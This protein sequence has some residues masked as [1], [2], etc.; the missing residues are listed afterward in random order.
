LYITGEFPVITTEGKTF[1]GQ[2]TTK[3]FTAPAGR[4]T[5]DPQAGVLYLTNKK[6]GCISSQSVLGL[7]SI[8]P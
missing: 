8:H 4:K 3:L 6:P 1:L 5:G 7:K 2:Q